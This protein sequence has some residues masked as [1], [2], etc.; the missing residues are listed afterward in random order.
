M[1]AELP[2]PCVVRAEFA[3]AGVTVQVLGELDV[4]STAQLSA[5]LRMLQVAGFPV[6]LDLSVT[7]FMDCRGLGVVL[8]A[9][10]ASR[11]ARRPLV[12]AADRA[13]CVT[14]LIDLVGAAVPVP[15]A[16]SGV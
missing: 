12:V 16:V 1:I 5:V 7:R 15:Q 13:P 2:E 3:G 14:R 11:S 6:V 8:S 9:A 4:A 10:R